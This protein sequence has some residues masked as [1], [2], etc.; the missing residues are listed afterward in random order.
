[1]AD[2]I[3][4][5]VKWFCGTMGALLGAL[6]GPIEATLYGLL[7][8]VV[9]DYATGVVV[10]LVKHNLSSEIGFKG[11]MK[12]VMIFAL[13]ALGHIVD[14]VVI[15]EG[16]TFRSAVIFFYIANEG[17]SILENA[18]IIGLPIPNKLKSVLKQLKEEKDNGNNERN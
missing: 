6:L 10:A 16:A 11:I 2:E 8:C 1:M 17:I 15:K 18:A 9:L 4:N 14:T 13:V 7:T 3:L 12:K 5:W